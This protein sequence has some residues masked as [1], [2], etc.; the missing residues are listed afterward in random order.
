MSLYVMPAPPVV[1]L[2]EPGRKYHGRGIPITDPKH[3]VDLLLHLIDRADQG[4]LDALLEHISPELLDQLR[5]KT[6]AELLRLIEVGGNIVSVLINERTL[7]YAEHKLAQQYRRGTAM[8][9]FLKRGAPQAMMLELFGLTD[10]A[11]RDLRTAAGETGRP[12]RTQMPSQDTRRAIRQTWAQPL[13]ARDAHEEE[14][15]TRYKRL[16]EAW[17]DVPL[18]SLYAIIVESSAP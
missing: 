8:V 13:V 2:E 7:R 3:A 15:V 1:C 18:A 9:W 5:N 11:Y 16:A 12:G 10:R 4:D 6:A 17:P 14:I